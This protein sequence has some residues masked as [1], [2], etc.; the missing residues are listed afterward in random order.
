[1]APASPHTEDA[2]K[3]ANDMP[4]THLALL[5]GLNVGGKNRL[6]MSDLIGLFAE[7]GCEHVRSYIQSGNVIFDADPGLAA[8]VASRVA[9][10]IADRFGYRTPV[11]LRTGEELAAV[12]ADNPFL[13]V[14][15]AEDEL[16]VYFLADRPDPDR[17]ARLDPDRSPSDRFSVSGR[18]IYLRLP[19]GMARTKLTNAYFDAKL[20]T[21][22]TAR[23][24]RTVTR[25]LEL[26]RA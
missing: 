6:P 7:S 14:G 23:N 2:A 26:M 13:A 22:S 8:G 1:M 10:R 24:W 3:G 12:I 4:R 21:T 11:I 9:A 19:H 20:A 18:E 5:R 17:V 25:L 15:C 16:H